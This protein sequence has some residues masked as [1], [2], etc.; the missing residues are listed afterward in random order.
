MFGLPYIVPINS[1]SI[2]TFN[3]VMCEDMILIIN[4]IATVS[5]PSIMALAD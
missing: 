5:R 4:Q 2:Y 1:C 3:D